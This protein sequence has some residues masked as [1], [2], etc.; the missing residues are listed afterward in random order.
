MAQ[1]RNPPS[2][3]CNPRGEHGTVRYCFGPCALGEV[4][5]ARTEKGICAVS[6]G[7]DQGEMAR[8]FEQH[9][10]GAVRDEED[11]PL[12]L[13]LARVLEAIASPEHGHNLTLDLRGSPF[14]RRV[15][16]ALCAIPCGETASYSEL[17]QRIGAPKAVRAVAS[18]CAANE[19]AVLV[20]CHRAVRNDG[21]ISGYRW[22][23][24]LKYQLLA[25]EGHLLS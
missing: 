1:T 6:I 23:V 7:P 4:L 16:E 25:R 5:A 19:I 11:A 21:T 10:P 14:Q 3:P 20:P 15:W 2:V 17:A 9:F 8:D 13:L 22:G 24:D 18:A 12:A